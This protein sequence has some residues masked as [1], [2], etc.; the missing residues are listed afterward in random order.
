MIKL[1]EFS[2][3]RAYRYWLLRAWDEGKPTAMCIGLNPSTANELNDDATITRL[4]GTDHSEG[5]ISNAGFGGFYMTNLFGLVTPYPQKLFDHPNALG[6]NDRHLKEIRML[7]NKVIFCWGNFKVRGRDKKV[8][9]MFS[10]AWC[11]GRN[12]NG[13]PK[14]PLY[15]PKSTKLIRYE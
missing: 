9:E 1:A 4:A 7:C 6:D 15:L 2:D 3:D 11:F 10:D 8:I 13:S 12:A 14:H 5:L